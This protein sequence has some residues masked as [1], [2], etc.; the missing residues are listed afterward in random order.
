MS[1]EVN[2]DSNSENSCTKKCLRNIITI[3]KTNT[4]FI[5]SPSCRHSSRMTCDSL[6]SSDVW[7]AWIASTCS[8]CVKSLL[9]HIDLFC[10]PY[11]RFATKKKVVLLMVQSCVEKGFLSTR[12]ARGKLR[13]F[14]VAC[15]LLQSIDTI[16]TAFKMQY[17]CAPVIM[18]QLKIPQKNH[19]WNDN[20]LLSL[21]LHDT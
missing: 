10:W 19:K 12:I 15:L 3:K 9:V 13:L 21:Y 7:V 16:K 17:L 11:L 20:L 5:Q 8:M 1:Q 18:A 4:F 14:H 2:M 6:I